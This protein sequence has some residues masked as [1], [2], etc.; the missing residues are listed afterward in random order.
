MSPSPRRWVVGRTDGPDLEF[1]GAQLARVDSRDSKTDRTQWT[2]LELY[3]TEGGRWI[4]V[5]YRC[6]ADS[7]RPRTVTAAN[8]ATAEEVVDWIGWGRL[9]KALL[10]QAGIVRR[11]I[12]E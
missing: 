9:G 6:R 1:R 12:V 5:C 8:L 7:P 11:E 2:V 3:R 4:P 10:E